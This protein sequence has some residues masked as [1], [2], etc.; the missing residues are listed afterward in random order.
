MKKHRRK[1]GVF[2]LAGV[3]P[4][5]QAEPRQ[6]VVA[7]LLARTVGSRL[8]NNPPKENT[9]ARVVF[10]FGGLAGARTQDLMHVKHAL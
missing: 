7:S 3:L 9:A 1:G 2:Y 8:S 4:F 5:P 6:S 10:S